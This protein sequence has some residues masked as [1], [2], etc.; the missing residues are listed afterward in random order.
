MKQAL[1]R[2]TAGIVIACVLSSPA[3]GATAGA[4]V[5]VGTPKTVYRIQ[6]RSGEPTG[7]SLQGNDIDS[8]ALDARRDR[9]WLLHDDG[10]VSGHDLSGA[11]IVQMSAKAIGNQSGGK[12]GGAGTPKGGDIA[13][14]H[15]NGGVYAAWGRVLNILG[16]KGKALSSM[17][18]PGVIRG[19]AIDR[20]NGTLWAATARGAY[21]FDA[22]GKAAGKI[23]IGDEL[24]LL[25][26]AVTPSTHTVLMVLRE[27]DIRANLLRAYGPHGKVEFEKRLRDVSRVVVDGAGGFWA[28][29]V[30]NVLHFDQSLHLLGA[31]AVP[32]VDGVPLLSS[33]DR[34]DRTLW[35][36]TATE[37][38]HLDEHCE[39]HQKFAR[40][41]VEVSG[42]IFDDTDTTPPTV[43]LSSPTA[44]K[45][46]G[47]RP[48]LTLTYG[49]VGRGIDKKSLSLEIGGERVALDCQ[50][51][52][53]SEA[54][55]KPATPI[56]DPKPNLVVS[57]ADI[58]GNTTTV[59]VNA[60]LD[61]DGDG[62]PDVNDRFPKDP[63]ET[64]DMDGDGI[65]D[66]SDPD[67]DGDG[68]P[69]DK[70]PFP[71]DPKEWSDMDH[72][73][74]GDNSDPDIDG[75]GVP[76]DKDPF[77]KDPKEWADMDHDGIGDNSDPD[78]DGDGVPNDKD[79][80][81]K[82]PKEW[83]DMD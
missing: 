20:S 33:A 10:G 46:I 17:R 28:T 29:G 4:Y 30:R 80:F 58:D 21:S 24:E 76:N 34:E 14:N 23:E 12:Q 56:T 18:L 65:G 43:T 2:A 49:D 38:V 83:A 32:G 16:P 69:N 50:E 42:I 73:G 9:V 7:L 68:V 79:P 71:K 36:A 37:F 53:T 74:I 81:P 11:R 13:V 82:D 47:P 48:E 55:C 15:A 59:Q 75:D 35:V 64:T 22:A 26:L 45:I 3:W 66:N 78:I 6:V 51:K 67:I 52:T 60:L 70:D 72:D 44:G 5:W 1:G 41:G 39:V 19:L 77:P 40:A 25:D 54:R 27:K 57:L 31:V 61:T 62:V 63:K 8:F